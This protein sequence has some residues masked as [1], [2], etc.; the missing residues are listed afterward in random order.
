LA[1]LFA[2]QVMKPMFR[3]LLRLAVHPASKARIVRLRGN[4]V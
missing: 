4:Y 1:R 3:G 2:E